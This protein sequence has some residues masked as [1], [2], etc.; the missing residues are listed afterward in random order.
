MKQCLPRGRGGVKARG[1]TQ[2]EPN[3]EGG[4]PFEKA[5]VTDAASQDGEDDS[6]DLARQLL[7]R[8]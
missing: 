3:V 7:L 5:R 4:F 2:T 6:L 1:R 8:L